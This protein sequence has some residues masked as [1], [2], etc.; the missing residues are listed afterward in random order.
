MIAGPKNS[1]TE[2]RDPE[3]LH[4]AATQ[5]TFEPVG[6]LLRA[7]IDE[8][9]PTCVV[10]SSGKPLYANSAY[11]RIADALAAAG[12]AP[13]KAGSATEAEHSLAS[14]LRVREST[15]W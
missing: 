6:A 10:D 2:G 14:H 5:S 13:A 15:D 11:A 8:G 4:G 1:L 9:S 7:L 3:S 12:A